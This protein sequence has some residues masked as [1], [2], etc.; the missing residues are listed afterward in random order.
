LRGRYSQ[1]KTS[2][3]TETAVKY[4][5]EVM[6]KLHEIV[7][8]EG[9]EIEVCGT[10]IWLTGNTRVVKEDLKKAGFLWCSKKLA[11]SW[12]N[13]EKEGKWRKSNLDLDEIRERHGSSKVPTEKRYAF[14]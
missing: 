1:F 12:H 13:R 6:N 3:E 4:D 11:W 8:L 5:V 9:I 10:W 2:A 7:Y 14:A